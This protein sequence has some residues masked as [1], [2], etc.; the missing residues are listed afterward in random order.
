VQSVDY[1]KITF[2]KRD[3]FLNYLPIDLYGVGGDKKPKRGVE[4]TPE[5]VYL[6]GTVFSLK[7]VNLDKFKVQFVDG[8]FLQEIEEK[9]SWFLQA[10]TSD[11]II[12]KNDNGIVWY[13]GVWRCGRW[14]SGTWIS[15]EWISGDWY[16]G[17]WYSSPVKSNILSV[18]VSGN[19]SDNSLSKWQGGRWFGGT[20][21]GGT[22]YDGRRYGGDWYGG[23]WFNGVWN[24]GDWYGGRFQGGIWVLGNWSGGLFNCDSRLSYWLDGK[25]ESGDFENGTW[26]NGQFGNQDN[27]LSRFGTRSINTRISVWHGGKWIS[28]EFHSSLN[29]DEVLQTPTVSDVHTLSVW[30]TGLWLGGSFYGGVAYNIDFRGGIWYGGI[31]EEI[32]VIGVDSIYVN[33]PDVSNNRIW[34]NGIFKF[35]PGDQIYI[36]DDFRGGT[37]SSIGTNDN[38]REY[39]INKIEEDEQNS[40]TGLFLNFNL[41]KLDPQIDYNVGFQDWNGIETNLRVV[42]HFDESNWKSGYW[43]NGYF[44]NGFFESGVWY[45]GVF[46]GTWGN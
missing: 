32:Q 41:S 39:R 23:L 11:A 7:N 40:R 8:L 27:R 31:L 25:F 2:I 21:Y 20:W 16:G 12:G 37:F 24:D 30:R 33:P 5:M 46:E 28:G 15:G 38:P 43:T 9:F 1:G 26:Y 44:E 29:F 22:W 45:N 3:K 4:V 10:E 36:I 18:Q 35:N 42:S 6:E 17:E 14:F 13:S 34:V 19:N